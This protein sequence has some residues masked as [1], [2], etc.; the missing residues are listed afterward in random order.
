MASAYAEALGA[1]LAIVAKERKSATETEALYLIGE[2]DG[3]DV[4][5]VDDLTETAPWS[6]LTL[7][8]PDELLAGEPGEPG[9]TDEGIDRDRIADVAMLAAVDAWRHMHSYGFVP[10]AAAAGGRLRSMFDR[11]GRPAGDLR[12]SM[13]SGARRMP[14]RR[15]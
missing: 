8:L 9:A 1:N 7:S 13:V 5:L 12:P 11:H 2:V 4:L 14:P 3:H 6:V 10:A 15:S